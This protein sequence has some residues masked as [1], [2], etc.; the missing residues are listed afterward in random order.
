M[1]D[2]Y[3]NSQTTSNNQTDEDGSPT[4]VN[5]NFPFD[6]KQQLNNFDENP[7]TLRKIRKKHNNSRR[8]CLVCKQRKIK[9]DQRF[10]TCSFCEKKDL[11]CSYMTMTPLQIYNITENQNDNSN[12]TLNI[13]KLNKFKYLNSKI[14]KNHG[15]NITSQ[16]SLD[17]D[18]QPLNNNIHQIH[19]I[20]RLLLK[21]KVKQVSSLTNNNNNEYNNEYSNEYSNYNY[22]HNHH[23]HN[24][25]NNNTQEINS[26]ISDSNSFDSL[27]EIPLYQNSRISNRVFTCNR[28]REIEILESIHHYCSMTQGCLKKR[29]IDD[30]DKKYFIK[31]KHLTL[32]TLVVVG[33]YKM[34]SVNQIFNKLTRCSFQ[35]FSFDYYKNILMIQPVLPTLIYLKKIKISEQCEIESASFIDK[36]TNIIKQEY[37]PFFDEFSA[38]KVNLFS[39]CFMI[40]NYCLSY[41]FKN[42]SK[43]EI[44]LDE[45]NRLIKLLGIFSTGFYSIV[46]N[47]S[48]PELLMTGT[49]VI[50]AYLI[51][52]FKR[53]L[54]KSY[55]IKI[56]DEFRFLIDKLSYRYINDAAYENLKI[57]YEKYLKLLRVNKHDNSL[58]GFNN[59]F[60]LRILNSYI[61]IIPFD[62]CNN[63]TEFDNKLQGKELNIILCFAYNALG[64]LLNSIIPSIDN[65][66]LIAFADPSWKMFKFDNTVNIMKMFNLLKNKKLQL[67][68]IYL[69]RMALFFKY[70]KLYHTSYLM[71]S[72]LN[73][74]LDPVTNM[75][76]DEIC[77]R[78]QNVKED[79]ILDEVHI[80]TFLLYKGQFIKRW[81]YPNNE[82]LKPK[83]T[84]KA[85]NNKIFK[86]FEGK[87]RLNSS[88]KNED[89]NE[90][91]DLLIDDFIKSNNGFFSLDFDPTTESVSNNPIIK[92]LSNTEVYE[93]ELAWKL[94]TFIRIKNK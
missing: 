50:S 93:I 16:I 31:D 21:N 23:H 51:L 2:M 54:I 81:N 88:N 18:S 34:L 9:C 25:N 69:I 70:Q 71:N 41:H 12:Y 79:G 3:D 14:E 4:L 57:F 91:E 7:N 40:L 55:S 52:R 83:R 75:S 67:T 53:L 66:S 27:E 11:Q 47:R 29:Y 45:S 92:N 42:G 44:S 32:D 26:S 8:G 64:H 80:K 22:N 87:H 6:G 46:M 24:K 39:C 35:L 76:V 20:E 10:P 17:T 74:L 19:E 89:L 65:V 72:S 15:Y 59:G 63:N 33:Y 61:S 28:L 60:L 90:I 49:N 78:L 82:K 5:D 68:A 37:L 36:T 85:S 1:S 94:S 73:S 58:L 30:L 62:M 56:F 77:T 86:Y 13:S 48:K 84:D 38:G 43:F